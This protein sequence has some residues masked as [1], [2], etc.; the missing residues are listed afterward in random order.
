MSTIQAR[1]LD[2]LWIGWIVRKY[3]TLFVGESGAGK[4]TVLADIVARITTGLA[5]PGETEDR[6][7][8]RVLWLASEDGAS[9]M[10]VPRLM[11]CNADLARVIE[12]EGVK[13]GDRQTTF[14]MQDDIE[15][16]KQWLT[17][18]RDTQNDPFTALVIDPVTSYLPG[19]KLR[20]VD[21]NDTGQLR[22]ILEPWFKVAQEFNIALICVTHFNKDETRSMLHR[23]TGSAVFA[24]TCRSLCALVERPDEGE[25]Q[26][27]MVQ[28]KTNLPEH[29]GGAWTFETKKVTVGVD[30]DN[31]NPINAT[32]PIWIKEDATITPRSLMGGKRGPVGAD[33]GTVFALW[34]KA[35]F[36]NTDLEEGLPITPL[37]ASAL[38]ANICSE[39]WW[40][41]HSGK[42]LQKRN[43]GGTWM[44]RPWP[45]L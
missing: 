6:T 18:A 25:F 23:V 19:Q 12:I 34:L 29:P 4:S 30:P 22:S 35:Q 15:S 10:T 9:D 24:Q 41:T 7:P 21:M 38:A 17:Y 39:K 26:K 43:D 42:Y 8:G 5:W 27:A 28:V 3:I 32:R 33:V 44:C 11:A 37:K 20:K 40:E 2:W 14:S 36:L 45:T 16:V 1:A 31:H 13:Q